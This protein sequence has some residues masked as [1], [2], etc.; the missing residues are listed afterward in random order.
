MIPEFEG[1]GE[2]VKARILIGADGGRSTVRA[3]ALKDGAPKYS[4][5]MSW[6]G[7]LDSDSSLVPS[8]QQMTIIDGG[9][10]GGPSRMLL[11]IDVQAQIIAWAAFAFMTKPPMDPRDKS[12]CGLHNVACIKEEFGVGENELF[13]RLIAGTDP[14]SILPLAIHDRDPTQ[15][16]WGAGR[17]S[18]VGDA[19]HL[20]QPWL[21]QG[22]NTT[23]EDAY[24]LADILAQCVR[25]SK[26]GASDKLAD[27]S[28]VDCAL[29]QY[30]EKRRMRTDT[31][32]TWS[33]QAALRPLDQKPPP[34]AMKP[35]MRSKEE[36][37]WMYTFSAEEPPSPPV[38]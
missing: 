11:A 38:S 1:Q 18:L 17:V 15:G 31:L 2:A 10:E 20:M 12:I 27:A 14:D 4:G 23:I 28:V 8:H 30:E 34:N 29:R 33:S 36:D 5:I 16:S 3:Q 6:R 32:Q 35:F 13:D 26:E 37:D 21:G 22:T 9:P 24:V 19:A 7:V 25:S